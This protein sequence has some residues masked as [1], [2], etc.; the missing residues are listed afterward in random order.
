MAE[1]KRWPGH[2]GNVRNDIFTKPGRVSFRGAA[3]GGEVERALG[4]T[5][6]ANCPSG[7]MVRTPL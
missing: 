1:I 3:P 4:G 6:A 2:L 7:A 5:M